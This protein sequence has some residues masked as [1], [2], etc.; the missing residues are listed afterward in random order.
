MGYEFVQQERVLLC[1][2]VDE[3]GVTGY[4]VQA[5]LIKYIT[6]NDFDACI[7]LNDCQQNVQINEVFMD[8]NV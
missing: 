6:L 7:K 1:S 4:Q 3:R 8:L 2:R 5:F